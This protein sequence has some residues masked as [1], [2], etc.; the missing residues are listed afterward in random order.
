MTSPKGLL[1]EVLLDYIVVES[2][3]HKIMSFLN[4]VNS[5]FIFHKKINFSVCFKTSSHL[6]TSIS[7]SI[8]PIFIDSGSKREFLLGRYLDSLNFTK[9]P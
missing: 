7:S 5:I 8:S 4:E 9:F 1:A 2:L 6:G 3:G